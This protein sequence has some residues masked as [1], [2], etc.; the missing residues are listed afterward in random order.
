M[1]HPYDLTVPQLTRMLR[2]LDG[3]LERAQGHGE[4]LLTARL[5]PDQWAFTRQV[6]TA[7]DNAKIMCARATGKTAPSHPDTET[8]YEQL[9][10]RIASVTEYLAT[11][12]RG[13]FDGVHERSV[14]PSWLR[15]GESMNALD[16]LLQFAL[17]NFQFHIVTAYAILRHHG[18]QLA[19]NDYLHPL[20]VA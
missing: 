2:N 10:A 13:D 1:I 14:R 9:R 8:T 20:V 12:E 7:C 15:E 4:Q 17:P 16:Y 19:K 11:F 6:Q 3:W 18:V 5:A